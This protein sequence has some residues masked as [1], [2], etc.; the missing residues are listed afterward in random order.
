MTSLKYILCQVE[1]NSDVLLERIFS[2]NE[3]KL[4]LTLQKRIL[5]RMYTRTM[6]AER[7]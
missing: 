5:E 2:P 6:K 7:V 3:L 1:V 4:F